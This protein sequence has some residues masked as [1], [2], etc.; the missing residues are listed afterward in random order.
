MPVAG[1]GSIVSFAARRFSS[2]APAGVTK[3]VTPERNANLVWP[4]Y[5]TS[6]N[7]LTLPLPY[8][9]HHVDSLSVSEAQ[10]MRAS[11]SAGYISDLGSIS[12]TAPAAIPSPRLRPAATIAVRADHFSAVTTLSLMPSAGRWNDGMIQRR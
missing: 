2:T 7:P 3:Q 12:Q 4:G 11:S 5:V 1:Q 6:G 8:L 10:F 9:I